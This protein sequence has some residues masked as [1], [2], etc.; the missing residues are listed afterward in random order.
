M[1]TGQAPP[2]ARRVLEQQ[3]QEPA[4]CQSQQEQSREPQ[5]QHR[6]SR[7]CFLPEHSSAAG[8]GG[9]DFA[10]RVLKSPDL[11]RRWE[12]LHPNI[13]KGKRA[14]SLTRTLVCL[15]RAKNL[16]FFPSN[17]YKDFL[18]NELEAAIR[19]ILHSLV[20]LQR[21]GG[22]EELEKIPA[23]PE[24]LSFYA[25]EGNDKNFMY[26]GLEWGNA[27]DEILCTHNPCSSP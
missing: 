13:N 26:N 3:S 1:K 24:S 2:D 7:A 23:Y 17:N 11:L 12:R 15:F 22:R 8:T 10:G 16:D 20:V 27:R 14:G 5:Q 21:D 25:T 19:W 6:F 9:R 4:L 18:S